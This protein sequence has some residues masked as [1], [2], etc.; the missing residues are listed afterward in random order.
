MRELLRKFSEA[1]GPSGREQ[2]IARLISEEIR[3]YVDEVFTDTLGNLYAVRRGNGTKVM[4]AAHM[5]EVGVIVTF[6]EEKGFLRFSNIGGLS[7]YV[8]LGQK[9]VFANG[10][11]GTVGMEKLEDI[12][13]L[14]LDKMYIDIGA[15]NRDEAAAKVRIGDIAVY[16]RELTVAGSRA[17]GK[18]MDNRA[19][20]AVLVNALKDLDQTDNE[21]YAVFT[22]QEE[23]GLRGSRTS[24]YRLNPELGLAVDVTPAGDTPEPP[25][26]MDVSLGRGPA[27]KVKDASII[28]HPRLKELLLE[29]AEREGIPCQLEVLQSGGTDAGAIHLSRDGIPSAVISVPCRYLHTP[30]EMADLTDMENASRLLKT[31]LT[32]TL[33]M[34]KIFPCYLT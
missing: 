9:V 21:I 13:K 23:V 19:G 12:K 33:E 14:A 24:S 18:A 17:V 15:A 22:V 2:Q 29:L 7:P 16:Y 11:V 20:C 5:D 25:A 8:L 30:G 10:T 32:H 31:F 3:E 28:C 26:A 6:I 1:Y 34:H 27:I 4:V